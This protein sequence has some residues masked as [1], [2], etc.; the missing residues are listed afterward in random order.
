MKYYDEGA[1][2]T[3]LDDRFA[4]CVGADDIADFYISF[5]YFNRRKTSDSKR[6]LLYIHHKGEWKFDYEITEKDNLRA[7]DSN[8]IK[9]AEGWDDFSIQLPEI[10]E[11]FGLVKEVDGNDYLLTEKFLIESTDL[12]RDID[13]LKETDLD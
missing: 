5:A 2:S 4:Y 10:M 8:S 11:S 9:F 1:H 3:I 7:L 6:V 13:Y 12:D